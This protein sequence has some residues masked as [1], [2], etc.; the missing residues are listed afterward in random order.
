M[1]RLTRRAELVEDPSV[2]ARTGGNKVGSRVFSR[3]EDLLAYYGRTA[4]RLTAILAPDCAPVT[5][6]A[7]WVRVNDAIRALRSFGIGP[8]DRVAVVLPNGPEAAVAVVAVAAGA[9]CVPL[10]PG[11]TAD[12]WQRYFV[13]LRVAALLTHADMDS[14]SRGVA[15]TLGIPVIDLSPRPDE[16]AGAFSLVSSGPSCAVGSGLR[17]GVDHAFILLTSGST[18][19]AK[20][21]PLT[22]AGVCLSAYNVGA[23]LALGPRDRLLN[24]QPLFHA[25]GL[26]SGLLAALAAGSSVVCTKGFDV[27][28]FFDWLKEFR[29][30]WYTAVPTIHR[31]VLS[32]ASRHKR[33]VQQ[34]SLR[35]IRSASSTLPSDVLNGL[36]ALFGV[37]VIDSYGM[38][39]AASQIAANPLERRKPGSVG[40]SA[41]AEITIM[42]G[43]GRQLT[44][45]ERGEIVLRG[46][47]ITSGY[48]DNPAAN[49]AAFRDG[50][51]RTGDLGYLDRE[52]YLFI[53]G[54]IK[55]V[56]NRG[57]QKVA[58]GDVE[59]TLLRH[60]DVVEAVAFPIA[61]RRLGE[62]VAAAVVL[63]PNAKVTAL[64]LRDFARERLARFK[65]PGLIHILA[66]IPKGPSGKIKR[67]E[68]AAA[69]SMT[70]PS[71]EIG[72]GGKMAPPR[73]ELQRQLAESWAELLEL[74]QIG[75]DQDVRALGADSLT[76]TQMLS[77]LRAHFGVDFSLQDI[78]DAPTVEALAARLESSERKSATVS[79]S[80][81]KTAAELDNVR[82]SF[83]QQ[84]IHVLSKLDSTGYS[85]H[86][87]EI[88][89]LSGRLDLDLL[90]ESI[91]AVC[92]RHEVLRTIFLE[93]LGEPLQTVTT[94]RLQV[95]R[96]DLGPC[97]SGRRAAAIQRQA[98]KLLHQSFDIEKAPPLRVQ[99]L[100][101]D[102]DDHALLIK[103]HHLIT[104]GWSQRLFWNELAALYAAKLNGPTSRL[105][106][107]AIQ[108]RHF[109]EWQR[110]WLVT[111]AAA[112]QLTYW[113]SQL[114]GLAE[115]P[116]R[117]DRPRPEIWSGRGARHPLKF[118]R[119][120]S[121][122][123]K[124]LGRAHG[125]TLFMTLLAAFQCLLHRYTA[126][127]D[128]AVGSVIA[129]RNQ[130]EIE[131][132]M[133]M[134]AN[135]IVLRTD[136][137]GDPKF[138]EVLR[139]VRQVTLDAQRNQD[140]PFE[141]I[142]RAVQASR[143]ID[144]NA[145]FQVMFTL[146]NPSP[147]APAFPG[148]S[149]RFMD[150]DPG[151]ARVDLLLE[152]VD[153]NEH[154]GGW[155]EYSTDLFDAATMGRMAAHL[156][157]MLE[158]IVANPEERISRLPLLSA[159]ERSRV[160]VDWNDTQ[161][162]FRH[163]GTF[164]ERFA[165]QAERTPEA[166]AVSAGSVQRSYRELARR[167]STIAQ[168]L[169]MEGV[170]PDVVVILL[171]ERGVDLLAAM[172]AVQRAG[173]AFLPLAPTIPAA[174]LT[175]IIQHSRTPVVLTGQGGAATLKKALS[176]T[177][178]QA[179]PQVL[180]LAALTRASPRC[181]FAPVRPA[182]S[183]LA[184]VIYT[185]GSTGVAKGAMV[186]QRGMLNHLLA[187][188]SDLGLSASDVIAQTAPQT[189][190]IS[191]WQFLAALMVGARVHICA[192]AEVRDPAQLGEVIRRE[193]V[194]VLQIVPSL[195]RAILDRMPDE[196]TG[197]ALSQLRCLVCIGEA[198]ASDLCRSWFQH[199]PGVPLINAYGPAECSDTVATHR[200]TAPPTTSLATVPI[201]RAIAN[202]RLY[203]LD[204]HMQPVPIG[205]AGELCVGGASVGRGYLNDPGQTERAFLH[206]P[207]TP[208]RGARLYR[209]G[210]LAR[211]RAEGNL[212]F[213]GRID[214]QVKV[215]GH[216]IELEE[217]EHVLLEHPDVQAAVV[218]ARD[219]LGG[220]ARLVAHIV[221]AGRREPE[222]NGL[223]DFLK[224][225]LQEYMIPT[226]FVFLDRIPLTAHG[227]IDR[228]ALAAIGERPKVA[229][230]EFVAPRD[231][232]E[233]ALAKIWR[234]LLAVEQIGAFDNFFELG[235]HSLLAGRALARAAKVFGV[236]LPLRAI[237]QAP[238]VAALARRINEAR[239]TQSNE[240]TLKIAR[241]QRDGPQ[242]VSITQE[243]MLRIEREFPA[244]PQF[245]LPFAYRLRGPLN[246]PALKR[247]LAEVVR[248]HDALRMRFTYEDESPVAL[249][250]PA[251]E[252]KLSLVV[253]DLVGR[254]PCGNGR[255]KALLLR[256]AQLEA[257]QEAW[258]PIGM[259]SAP[260]FRMRLL[261]LGADDHV[262]LL[263]LHHI[264]V[265][266]WSVGVLMEEISKLYASSAAGRPAQLPK[267]THQ[268]SDF[269]RWQRRWSGSGAATQ[270]FAY[271]KCHLR[272]ASPV[273]P[274]TPDLTNALLCSPVAHEP[275]RVPKDLVACL[276][277]LS[278]RQGVT[279]FMTLLAGFKTL[280]MAQSGRND[281]CV[282]T[283]MAN[284]SQLSTERM[285]GPLVNTA[286]IR[287]RI[288]PD[289][290]FQEALSRVRDSVL[291]AYARQELPFDIL[292]T[293]LAEED[294]LDPASLIQVSLVLQ[295]ALRPLKL[296]D[297]TVRSFAYPDGQRVLPIDRTWLSVILKETPSG[298]TGA[299]NYKDDLFEPKTVRHWVAN[300]RAILAKAA[301]N[302]EMALG[303]LLDR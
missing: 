26:F 211:W 3:L 294:G 213:L 223:R 72:R 139:R 53:V 271:W 281:V 215:R 107:L 8:S 83:Q 35:L 296:P 171:D 36:E 218:L 209:T 133:G 290:S 184:Y 254:T 250:A 68:L 265:D 169:A 95:E 144:R 49:K 189:F 212:E 197:C 274:T 180:R 88:A 58:P 148:L 126:H 120:L 235:G 158:A 207:F 260:L 231:T 298:I 303:R 143:S 230:K 30:T 122:A 156:Q 299:C 102:Q 19:Q 25:H 185:S 7:V 45:G 125:V 61:H 4:S 167:S 89:R 155:L 100:R 14:A 39:E 275:I 146:Q 289:L 67:G 11:F 280:L 119:A 37:P 172:I 64:K 56:I 206:D 73:S 257:E 110:A 29:P 205:V 224:T 115:L 48:D 191:V 210:D 71:V 12:E 176:G 113:Q 277:S 226:G 285:I 164:Y 182:P 38:T 216:R 149:V 278:H 221:A 131:R 52:G 13:D 251:S 97:V 237:F 247:S 256:K 248:R 90:E 259:S 202:T 54:R 261:R 9:V 249:I 32:A 137:S 41:G 291:E 66:E 293:R 70:P 145:L 246:F 253:E 116:L 111:R 142:L 92:E 264:I 18:S 91:A 295:N 255:A 181:R 121:R 258:T 279:L 147:K 154:L 153:A 243:Q 175:Q 272:D 93:R 129:N 270:Q 192:D 297:V 179:R 127:D 190:D 79:L 217:I 268:F 33:G 69:V 22:H 276:R 159:Q 135:T 47:T 232:T 151:I 24:V 31:A 170:G 198:L 2:A 161:T 150:L 177:A 28:A 46:P 109:A 238:T 183:N 239:E 287:T 233:E 284:R 134:F 220:Y 51:F 203:V 173:G 130:I 140:L 82:L 27:A 117:A 80:L 81:R 136:L 186:E 87:F 174:R 75:V 234:D 201:G 6:G 165:R 302:P 20:M 118:S 50:W 194:T 1:V 288:D 55:D 74:D 227:K 242:P 263:I 76:M 236:S 98:R 286:L 141:E 300:Y 178:A 292:A 262:L 84:R 62:D 160:I 23:V 65:V 222:V 42:D 94:A 196:S 60:P 245:N 112:E 301:A 283:A 124:S 157:R 252:T 44:T 162:K 106:E 240:P 168:Q 17:S 267:P 16:G 269:A 105:P 77:R 86:T 78:F 200:V 187:R 199:F 214:R 108:Y 138:S 163:L 266:G 59:E 15:H 273:F 104:D 85:Y 219:E 225:K 63:R 5:Y 244:L 152:L 128:V 43:K 282:A 229:R 21:V 132:L 101:L 103:L 40:K 10:N 188:I 241:G 228:A 208:R 34:H 204:A 166:I 57:G 193:G 123:I 99:V 114:R 195:L 96:F